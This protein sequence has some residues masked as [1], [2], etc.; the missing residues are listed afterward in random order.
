MGICCF[1]FLED[2]SILK[3][4]QVLRLVQEAVETLCGGLQARTM[5]LCPRTRVLITGLPVRYTDSQ[6]K[7]QSE[8]RGLIA[9]HL[10]LKDHI[11]KGGVEVVSGANCP[12]VLTFVFFDNK[13]EIT[14]LMSHNNHVTI[15]GQQYKAQ[16]LTD[17]LFEH[18][19]DAEELL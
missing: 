4:Y 6:I 13:Y 7:P 19:L 16:I 17:K 18:Q 2:L 5:I 15:S 3:L 14:C 9:N 12:D 10:V 8:L 1:Y 11:I